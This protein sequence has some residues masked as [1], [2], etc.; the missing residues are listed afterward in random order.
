MLLLI[1]S[2]IV[3]ALIFISFVPHIYHAWLDKGTREISLHYLL[4]NAI[5]STEHLLMVFFY[6]INLHIDSPIDLPIDIPTEAGYWT[7]NPRNAL[8]WVNFVQV[9]GVGAQP[10]PQTY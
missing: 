6:T 5:C 8:D 4:F 10:L 1:I 7:H 2:L 3:L 9:L